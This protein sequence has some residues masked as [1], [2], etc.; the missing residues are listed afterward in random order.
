V[1]TRYLSVFA[2]ECVPDVIPAEACYLGWQESL[3]VLA[4]LVEAE[5]RTESREESCGTGA[6]AVFG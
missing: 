5:I 2:E 3:I 6:D 1:P 4:K